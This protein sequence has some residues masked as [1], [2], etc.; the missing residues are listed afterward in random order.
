MRRGSYAAK[1]T[2]DPY[3]E[4][5]F[6]EI[7]YYPSRIARRTPDWINDRE[8]LFY[9]LEVPVIPLMQEV[10]R[11]VYNES[12][13]L[14]AMSIRASLEI[15]MIDKVGDQGSFKA[16]VDA[17]QQEGYLSVRQSLTLAS[18]LEAGHATIHRGWV[19]THKDIT[20]L[21]DITESIIETV[22]LHEWRARD[23]EK[24]IPKRRRPG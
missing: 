8:V 4:E 10:Y 3:S 24:N 1:L 19:P 6:E 7:S 13:R 18:I 23:L 5:H 20:T 22:Y 16:N 15:L 2:G 11:A 12:R 14:A 9:L 17:L 21:L